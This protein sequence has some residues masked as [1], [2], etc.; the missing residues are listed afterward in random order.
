VL[1]VSVDLE[2]Y[3]GFNQLAVRSI[4]LPGLLPTHDQLRKLLL[5]L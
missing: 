1:S 3:S 4:E 2:T 5:L